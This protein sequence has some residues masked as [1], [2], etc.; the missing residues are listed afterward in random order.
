MNRMKDHHPHSQGR[1][2]AVPHCILMYSVQ[3]W[4]LRQRAVFLPVAFVE[5]HMTALGQFVSLVL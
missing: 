1:N 5:R 3:T 4:F 2:Y